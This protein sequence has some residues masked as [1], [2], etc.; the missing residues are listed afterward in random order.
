MTFTAG[1]S[2]GPPAFSTESQTANHKCV[3]GAIAGV[4]V[5]RAPSAHARKKH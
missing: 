3:A 2:H 1:G 5:R 4:Q